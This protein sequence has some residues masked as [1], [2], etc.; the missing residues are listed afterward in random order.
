[1][2]IESCL[3]RLRLALQIA[4]MGFWEVEVS[5][6]KLT[7][8]EELAWLYGY[9]GIFPETLKAFYDI[10]HPD[11]IAEIDRLREEAMKTHQPFEYDFRI[12]LPSG[13][14]RW[15]YNKGSAEYDEKGS[16]IRIFGINVDITERKHTEEELRENE[17]RYRALVETSQ[18][19]IW[20]CDREG[21]YIYLNPIGE[22]TFG[23]PLN[24]LIGRKF[25][26][27]QHPDT[28]A[29][30]LEEFERL[31]NGESVKGYKT[32]Y[33]GSD[34]KEITLTFNARPVYASNGEI[35]GTRGTA[36]DI[37]E[38]E[39]AVEKYQSLFN[40]MID[41]FSFHDMIFD[42]YGNPV[43]YR[44]LEVNPAFERITGLNAESIIGKTAQE[45]LP[46]IE[47]YWIDIFGR[48][49]SSGEAASFENYS[50]NLKKHFVVTAFRPASGQFASI[51]VD[52]T[53]RIQAEQGLRESE[54]RLR[55]IL[56]S[57]AD[58]VI[59]TDTQGVITRINP[60]AERL[61]GW[62]NGQAV[63][64]SLV[65]VFVV[66]N[67]DSGELVPDP[68]FRVLHSGTIVSM[69]SNTRLISRNDR[70]FQISDS[71]APIRGV[72]GEI[73]G[74]V[75]VFRDVTEEYTI[76]E[77]LQ[78]SEERYRLFYETSP[79]AI[80]AVK[81]FTL[82]NPNNSAMKLF[83]IS[84]EEMKNHSPWE[85][86]PERQ[87]DGSLSRDKA[88]YYI[89]EALAGHP[90]HF[91]WRHQRRDGTQFDAEVVLTR[92]YLSGEPQITATVI[93]VTER[94]N[95]LRSLE[96]SLHEKETLL[97]EIYHRTKNNMMVISSFL[98][99]Q[100]AS[101]ENEEVDRIIHDSVTRIR[102]MSLAHGMLYK[103][104]SLSRISMR[105][106]ITDLA[107]ILAK[108][109]G[110][111]PE[112][113]SL[114]FDIEEVEMLIDIAIPCGLIINELLSNCF[115]Y[116]FPDQRKGYITIG[117]R[118]IAEKQVEL[119]IRDNGIGLPEGFDIMQTDT[120]GVQLVTQIARHQ[121]H[122][123]IRVLSKHGLSWFVAFR[124]DLY[125]ER[126]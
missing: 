112:Q 21:R 86:S 66:V 12:R 67:S 74:A 101:V 105:D 2:N 32:R 97:Q 99:L 29:R 84:A 58:A 107:N 10:V 116:A 65:E 73:I 120:L 108:G 94:K 27:F 6:G 125:S 64:K 119:S 117:F 96:A 17:E 22:E 102:T 106:Y 33:I 62:L 126:V 53:D 15:I 55:T 93:D 16:P 91:E 28:A 20:Q 71:V 77:A 124:E 79:Y 122:A 68:I 61:T 109:S 36:H 50:R 121:L 85:L 1:M 31:K 5:T 3:K 48:V 42:K 60:A 37:T 110:F 81:S 111:S 87:P 19:L 90:Q 39:S 83:R 104:K 11:D 76:R 46:G 56:N 59:A 4:R 88:I 14:I 8:S 54:E 113:V 98:E 44:F 123:T 57:L 92:V 40:N 49:A 103:G 30:D 80:M 63:G 118:R 82:C 115:K 72:Q 51:F 34:G 23:Y 43:D 18:D 114:K 95:A 70:E 24:Q 89:K 41:G 52:I 7:T 78:E 38:L 35:M 25:T 100:A 13:E 47:Q 69:S 45:V 9:E 75:L 26:D